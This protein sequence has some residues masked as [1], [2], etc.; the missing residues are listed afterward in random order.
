MYILCWNEPKYEW[1]WKELKRKRKILKLEGYDIK[2]KLYKTCICI[3]LRLATTPFWMSVYLFYCIRC[4]YIYSLCLMYYV[5]CNNNL[6]W[7]MLQCFHIRLALF[8][9]VSTS[10]PSW[11]LYLYL[12][13]IYNVE[14]PQL[15]FLIKY[16]NMCMLNV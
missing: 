1:M 14:P 10:A 13:C 9:S 8:F 5:M 15:I 4:Y 11:N 2:M 3:K 6:S 7:T 16:S 12:T